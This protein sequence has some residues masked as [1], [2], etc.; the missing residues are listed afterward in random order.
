MKCLPKAMCVTVVIG[1]A[2]RRFLTYRRIPDR[3]VLLL[4]HQ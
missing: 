1:T 3:P 2:V 4:H